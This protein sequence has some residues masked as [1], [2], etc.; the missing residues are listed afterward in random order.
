MNRF[1]SFRYGAVYPIASHLLYGIIGGLLGA[2]LVLGIHR[3][4]PKSNQ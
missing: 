4:S 1:G 3:I 2:L